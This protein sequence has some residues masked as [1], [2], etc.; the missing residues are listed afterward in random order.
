M[1]LFSLLGI[2]H[3]GLLK[4]PLSPFLYQLV[5]PLIELK[6]VA[7][8]VPSQT[9]AISTT[10]LKTATS[11]ILPS[12]NPALDLLAPINKSF[13]VVKVPLL[14]NVVATVFNKTPFL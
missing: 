10:E 14:A 13:V 5:K 7:S 1:V 3:W 11:S 6:S 4:V 2:S 8:P 9:S 12:K